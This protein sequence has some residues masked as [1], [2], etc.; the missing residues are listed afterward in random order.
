MFELR[1]VILESKYHDPFIKPQIKKKLQYR[2]GEFL[3]ED[4]EGWKDVPEVIL[5]EVIKDASTG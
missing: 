3:I 2:F 4:E 1:W 5:K